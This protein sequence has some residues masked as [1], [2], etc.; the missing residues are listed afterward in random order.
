MILCWPSVVYNLL[1]LPVQGPIVNDLGAM[2]PTKHDMPLSEFESLLDAMPQLRVM[3][4]SPHLEAAGENYARIRALLKRGVVPA[5]GHDRVASESEILG[6][7]ACGPDR[8]MHI[9]HLFNVCSFHHR[10][11]NI[12][13][14]PVRIS[15]KH[16]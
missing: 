1:L 9:T 13:H 3:T 15:R 10:Y 6:A 16:F 11:N 8:Q 4:I 12:S 14:R 2:P 5:L 7:L